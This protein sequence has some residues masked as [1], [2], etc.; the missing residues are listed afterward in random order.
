[1]DI[2]SGQL[3]IYAHKMQLMYSLLKKRVYTAVHLRIHKLYFFREQVIQS[4][5][6]IDEYQFDFLENS[7][8]WR[9]SKFSIFKIEMCSLF[10]Y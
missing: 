8:K 6:F 9:F 10:Y 4:K 2:F 7:Q 5:R 1:M 3:I